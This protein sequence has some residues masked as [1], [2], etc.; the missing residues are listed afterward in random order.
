MIQALRDDYL[1]QELAAL[2]DWHYVPDR[3][4]IYRQLRFSDFG[5]ALGAMVRIGLEAE[6]ADHHPEWANVYNVLDI[7]LT[8]H[9]A[10]GVSNQD[11]A[12]ARKINAI[13]NNAGN[14]TSTLD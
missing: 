9:D 3:K 7:W 13:A 4:A 1:E 5:Q 6:K 2:P 10:E 14:H 12:L 8:T 11:I